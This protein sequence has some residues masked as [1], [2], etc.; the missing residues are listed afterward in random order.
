MGLANPFLITL[1]S[2][3]ITYEFPMRRYFVHRPAHRNYHVPGPEK[4]KLP[5]RRI[6]VKR[7]ESSEFVL[8]LDLLERVVTKGDAEEERILPG[9]YTVEMT[10][11]ELGFEYAGRK[12]RFVAANAE[13][14]YLL[15]NLARLKS[16]KPRWQIFIERSEDV[17]RGVDPERLS[18]P[19]RKQMG[20]LILL[21]RLVRSRKPIGEIPFGEGETASLLPAYRTEGLLL[22][23]E[24]ETARGDT[25]AAAATRE[26]VLAARPQARAL[27]DYVAGNGGAIALYR[28]RARTRAG[29][30]AGA[31]SRQSGGPL[32]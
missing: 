12:V 6:E 1:A 14:R 20:Y 27:L 24:I 17:M 31:A 13:E 5:L 4:L 2:D 7:G 28:K 9:E 18:D 11:P 10:D 25:A 16:E 26:A 23:Y 3:Q 32:P 19:G 22:R 15:R 30:G 29:S 8:D 21:A